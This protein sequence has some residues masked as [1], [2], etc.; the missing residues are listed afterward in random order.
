[1][2]FVGTEFDNLVTISVTKLFLNSFFRMNSSEL[3]KIL[4]QQCEPED[5]IQLW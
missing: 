3:I 5:D 2:S 4:V 1:M